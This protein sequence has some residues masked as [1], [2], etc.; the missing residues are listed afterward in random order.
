MGSKSVILDTVFSILVHKYCDSRIEAL[1]IKSKHSIASSC[2]EIGIRI[3]K[4]ATVPLLRPSSSFLL[5]TLTLKPSTLT[6]TKT[7]PFFKPKPQNAVVMAR[8]SNNNNTSSSPQPT[9][10]LISVAAYTLP[11]FNS[12]H[13]GRYLLAQH[14][15]LA[16]LFDPFIPFLTFYRSIPYSSFIAFFALYLGIVR[17]PNFPH[18]VRFNA[19]QAVT[20]DVLL[21][22]PLLLQRI[23]SPG[24]A[25]VGFR[26]LLWSHNVLFVFSVLCFLY[27]A[28]SCVM[29]R[30]PY[31]PFVADAASRQI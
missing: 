10:R 19:M 2:I 11:F 26:I 17:N 28:A 13:Y 5:P 21:V 4:M 20:L 22:I 25:G 9:E 18:F 31:L 6:L 29:G 12:L 14:P 23:F 27:S 1:K 24:R 16:L 8:M 15:N 3:Q 30:A 7:H